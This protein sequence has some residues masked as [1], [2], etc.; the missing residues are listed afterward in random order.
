MVSFIFDILDQGP[1]SFLNSIC[2]VQ[3]GGSN[4]FSDSLR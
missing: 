2:G 3:C 1:N 4:N